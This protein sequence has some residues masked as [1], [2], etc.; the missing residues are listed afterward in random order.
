MKEEDL[1]RLTIT[2]NNF[3]TLGE[4]KIVDKFDIIVADFGF[5]SYHL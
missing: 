1:R 4:T 3:S 2:Q 5:C